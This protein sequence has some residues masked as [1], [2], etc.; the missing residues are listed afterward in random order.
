M[1]TDELKT[2]ARICK[3]VLFSDAP[4]VAII[5]VSGPKNKYKIFIIKNF[6]DYN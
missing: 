1:Y 3:M 6:L 2:S 4:P 5:R